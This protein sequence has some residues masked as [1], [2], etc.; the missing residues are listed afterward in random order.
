MEVLE[1]FGHGGDLL[2]AKERY[3][4][5]P[6]AFL[7]YSANINPLGPPERVIEV[8]QDQFLQVVRY[9]D[10]A[11]RAFR[12]AL[13][14]RLQLP[15]EWLLPTNGA[16]EAMALA[17]LA[18]EPKTVGLVYP[19]F[20]EYAQL[21]R[22]FGAKLHGIYG[23]EEN[24]YKPDAQE[25]YALCRQADMVFV[26][27]PNN[28]TGLCYTPDELVRLAEWS[29]ETGTWLVVDEAFLD[30][31]EEEKQFSLAATLARY[32]RVILIR[33]M[34]KMYAIPGLRL[35]YAIALPEVVERMREKQVTWSVNALALLAGEHC[36]REVAYEQKTRALIAKER[37]YLIS[38][39]SSLPDWQVWPGEANFLL[40]RTPAWTDAHG[41]QDALGKSGVL[42]RSC[43][44]Y[45]G[46]DSRH[47]RIAVRRREDN[48][49]LIARLREF[50]GAH[51]K[52]GE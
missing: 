14:E 51:G 28:P 34:T 18:C 47:V 46:L 39:L 19:C 38:A 33:S 13:S 10:P 8:L 22:Q 24:G 9:P 21:S 31:L 48:E 6:D 42:I 23:R 26:G 4:I 1:K 45:P 41:L 50:C 52:G 2:T 25:L 27:S 49:R 5:G 43:A 15:A 20:S 40:V 16:A 36:L 11:H 12:H 29:E 30:F 35:G 3:G 44:M 17:I 37:A 7:D 32:P